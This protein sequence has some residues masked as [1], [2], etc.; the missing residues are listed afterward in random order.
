VSS[1]D[2]IAAALGAMLQRVHFAGPDDL[3][4]LAQTA[5]AELGADDTVIYLVD[6]DQVALIAL[7]SDDTRAPVIPVEGTVA[8][9]AFSD[10]TLMSVS[11][12]DGL[13]VWGPLLD[14]TDRF[15]VLEF[16][17]PAGTR[18]D[19]GF[20]EGC[21]LVAALLAELVITR[22]NYGD[23]IEQTRRRKP[24]SL[25]AELQ[26]NLLPP[27]T[28]V[29]P[30]VAIA[31]VLAP[32]HDVAGDSFDYAVNGAI[33]N[34]A[35]VDAMGHGLDATL[36]SAI[37]IGQL[38][39]SRRRNC[40][41]IDTAIAMDQAIAERFGPDKF[42][43]GIIGQLDTNTGAW[44]WVNC[45]HPPSLL[46]RGGHVVKKLDAPVNPPLGL[47]SGTPDISTERLEPGD[48]LLLYTD[49][50]TETRDAAGNFFGV[51]RLVNIVTKQSAAGR[52]A[53]ETLRRLNLAILQHQAGPLQDDATTVL[54][55]WLSNELP[56]SQVDVARQTR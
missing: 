13:S 19:E 6:Y 31:G 26:W 39:N 25:P 50:V 27:L 10:I 22:S 49:G 30:R 41:L 35:I 44:T 28:F 36:M 23:R 46:I 15:G 21:R 24:M 37:A 33:A 5:G 7:R 20:L 53:A 38:R 8:G 48:R 43:T 17:F 51:D 54:V 29:T 16:R 14:G 45:G 55:E 47:L 40:S 2:A 3:P 12:P 4:A 52:P 32:T 34:L 1:P 18:V 56:R 42:V 9:R 11:G